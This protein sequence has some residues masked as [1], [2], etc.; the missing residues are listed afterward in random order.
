MIERP[1]HHAY[2]A[3][4]NPRECIPQLVDYLKEEQADTDRSV[5][6]DKEVTETIKIETARELSSRG[7]QKSA[8]ETRCIIRGF[9]QITLPAQNALLK[10]IEEPAEGIHF[11]LITPYPDHLLE[12]IH[13][14]VEQIDICQRDTQKEEVTIL[15]DKFV[16]AEGIADRLEI[17][18]D[19]SDRPQLRRF[20]QSL[21]NH[22]FAREHPRFGNAL[23]KVID[24]SKDS[25]SSVKQLKQ[26]LA[27]AAGR[28]SHSE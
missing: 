12:T 25:G 8:G 20:A 18:E 16:S 15:R 13:S 9:D 7:R 2:L 27:M 17:V 22:S 4:G 23:E 24:F 14:R 26:F 28:S 10:I 11:F 6:I 19:I 3:A 5:L 1:L 21:A